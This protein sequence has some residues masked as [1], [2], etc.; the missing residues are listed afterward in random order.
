MNLKCTGWLAAATAGALF[1]AACGGG[2]GG[3]QSQPAMQPQQSQSSFQPG[4]AI[5]RFVAVDLHPSSGYA[6]TLGWGIG[7]GVQA[8]QSDKTGPGPGVVHALLWR[9][10]AVSVVDLHPNGFTDSRALATS[11]GVQ[12]G[13]GGPLG[14]GTH[15]LKWF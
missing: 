14:G 11:G 9:G 12:A 4:E 1:V 13:S 7:D 6:V 10:T 3:P 5:T 15:A 2:G 8:G